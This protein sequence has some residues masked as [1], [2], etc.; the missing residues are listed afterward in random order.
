MYQ[1]V[2]R[3][4]LVKYNILFTFNVIHCRIRY[5]GAV[6]EMTTNDLIKI[7][8]ENGYKIT[9]N[10]TYRFY[11]R[12]L[13][14]KPE[15]INLGG[16]QGTKAIFPE[17]TDKQLL[18]LC[19]IRKKSKDTLYIAWNLW[20]KGF[21]VPNEL[22][23][24]VVTSSI[25]CIYK[26]KQQWLNANG[27]KGLDNLDIAENIIRSNFSENQFPEKEKKLFG[28]LTPIQVNFFTFAIRWILLN[29]KDIFSEL[30]MD[31]YDKELFPKNEQIYFNII[32]IIVKKM[33]S[34][35]KVKPRYKKNIMSDFDNESILE[36]FNTIP[37]FG[38]EAY[39]RQIIDSLDEDKLEKARFMIQYFIKM[40]S[41]FGLVKFKIVNFE[42]YYWCYLI[43]LFV[44][45]EQLLRLLDHK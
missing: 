45:D 8:S 43:V 5:K 41:L 15:L 21:D 20:I 11:G 18:E 23:K 31:F 3:L 42:N 12:G 44:G 26:Q 32:K 7:A 33:L 39:I 36:H 14:P 34:R 1:G 37:S 13:I 9:Q 19:R 2:C 4:H 10:Q 24:D 28:I 27:G 30:E 35:I 17:G 38:D 6:C 25:D 40:C 29:D 16:R 22:I